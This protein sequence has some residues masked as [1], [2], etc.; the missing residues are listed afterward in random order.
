MAL[1]VDDFQR[2]G[3][4]TV[5]GLD[6]DNE[7]AVEEAHGGSGEG[8]ER[9]GI[10]IA[11]S[12]EGASALNLKA[13]LVGCIGDECAVGINERDGDEGEVLGVGF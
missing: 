13:Q 3:T 8:L 1:V 6:D 4:R 7:L 5:A 9:G 2:Q 12:T 10:A 11:D